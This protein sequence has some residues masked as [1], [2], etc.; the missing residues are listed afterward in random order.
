MST[1][2]HHSKNSGHQHSYELLC[3]AIPSCAVHTS[4]LG[5]RSAGQDPAVRRPLGVL[6][7]ETSRTLLHGPLPLADFYVYNL[8]ATDQ[9]CKHKSFQ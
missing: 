7:L 6:C 4:V 9:N 5:E 2:T 3:L 8:T 1:G